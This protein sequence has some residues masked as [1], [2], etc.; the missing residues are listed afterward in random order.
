MRGDRQPVGAGRRDA[1]RI[2]RADQ[3]VKQ[4]RAHLHEDQHVVGA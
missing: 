4:R 1:A 3:L 2:E